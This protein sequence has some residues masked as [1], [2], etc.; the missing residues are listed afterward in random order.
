MYLTAKHTNLT[1]KPPPLALKVELILSKPPVR[2][3]IS[4][5]HST[6]SKH[7]WR[8]YKEITNFAHSAGV[9]KPARRVQ[10]VSKNARMTFAPGAFQRPDGEVVSVKNAF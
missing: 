8:L 10:G 1:L 7:L 2:I 6:I 4:S 3:S 9:P 5:F